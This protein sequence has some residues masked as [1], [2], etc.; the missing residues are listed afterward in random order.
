M[1]AKAQPIL[2]PDIPLDQFI[3]DPSPEILIAVA[4]D[5]RLTED[6]A[7]ALLSRRDLTGEVL[8]QIHKHKSLAKLRKVQLALVLHP[9]TPRHVSIPTVRHLYTFELM[10]VALLPTVVADVKRA[11]EEVLISRLASV[12][13]GERFTLAK[14][15]SG[16]V[17]ASLLL[18]KEE[19]VFQGA[20]SN[21][22]M[23]E[24]WIVKTL[25]AEAGTELLAPALSRHG[26]WSHRNDVKAALL[27]NR[28][29]PLSRL[30]QIAADLPLN[31]LKDV[32]RNSKLSSSAK[33]Q[34]RSVLEKRTTGA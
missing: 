32:L 10:Q 27:A 4:A 7:L 30:A 1:N 19:R 16:R 34:L 26:K 3:H 9:H 13:S 28:F 17:A 20:L 18:D 33:T 23:T 8:E 14:R 24:A 25:K 29:T 6:L 22:Q 11:A 5:P 21:P 2:S 31:M 15:S 12:S